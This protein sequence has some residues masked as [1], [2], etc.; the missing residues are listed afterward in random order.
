MGLRSTIASAVDSAW[1]ALG[2]I[3]QNVTLRRITKT[4]SPTTG[5]WTDT[6]AD[7][8]VSAVLLKFESFEID[9]V[10]VIS[11]DRKC[12]VKSNTLVITPNTS[13]DRIVIGATIYSVV[14]VFQDPAGA[15]TTLQL[16]SA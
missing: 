6:N 10:N 4:Y 14:R 2:D 1:T 3:P 13:S 9:K 5:V 15:T 12:L 16:R 7:Y 8:T 11:T